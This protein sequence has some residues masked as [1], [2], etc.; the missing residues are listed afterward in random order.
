MYARVREAAPHAEPRA[1]GES[2]VLEALTILLVWV[3]V[4]PVPL[5]NV[6][7]TVLPM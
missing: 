1:I 2:Y 5:L 6:I 7:R 3:G 4:Y